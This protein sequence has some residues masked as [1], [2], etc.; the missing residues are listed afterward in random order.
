MKRTAIMGIS[1]KH[2]HL[3]KEH[4]E[5]LF[6][7]GHQLTPTKDLGQPG[8]YAC[9]ETVEVIG[10]KGSFKKVRVLGPARSETQVE[11][12]LTDSFQLGVK[13][14]VRDSG[15]IEGTPGV[16]LVG[17]AGQVE[18]E[19][20]V[21]IAARHIH[22]DPKTAENYNVK[23]KDIVSVKIDGPRGMI[24]NEVLIRVRDDFALEMH[25]DTDEGNAAMLSNGQIVEIV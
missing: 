5:I 21:I 2:L 15:D 6:G 4:I 1:N 14:P 17:P 24:L 23:D 19:R 8:Q 10:P 16:T 25:V 20:G 7:E 9:D 22:M 11:I 12:S 13:A 3:S 18:L